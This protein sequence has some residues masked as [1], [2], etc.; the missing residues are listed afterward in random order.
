V[1]ATTDI[2]TTAA[3]AVTLA[4]GNLVPKIVATVGALLDRV[5]RVE[6]NDTPPPE[7]PTSPP[8]APA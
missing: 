1:S 7:T 5:Q 3:G 4:I 6:E 8:P 2:V